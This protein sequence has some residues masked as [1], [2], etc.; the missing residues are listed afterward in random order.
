MNEKISHDNRENFPEDKYDNEGNSPEDTILKDNKEVA[1]EITRLDPEAN[2][3]SKYRE[4][5]K[6]VFSLDKVEHEAVDKYHP[7]V[8]DKGGEHVVY[9]VEGHRDVVVKV[10]TGPLKDTLDK[11]F[12][13]K[14]QK[15]HHKERAV[16]RQD[17]QE[18][19]FDEKDIM[20]KDIA[21]GVKRYE[22]MREWFGKEHVLPQ[23][24]VIAEVPLTKEIIDELYENKSPGFIDKV[25]A[26]ITVQKYTKEVND[27]EHLAI[28]SGYAEQGGVP[29][30]MYS[31]ATQ[32]LIFGKTPEQKI[33]QKELLKVQS[34]L[35]LKKLFSALE[36]NEEI[37]KALKEFVI[38]AIAYSQETGEILDIAG[39]DNIIF[40]KKDH[41]KKEGAWTHLLIDA[42]YPGSPDIIDKSKEVL[43]AISSGQTIGVNE[44]IILLNSFN[45]I[46]T[47]NGLAEQLG[48]E[49]R[50]QIAP[51]G[52]KEEHIDFLKIIK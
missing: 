45:Y 10:A 38:K 4:H 18:T 46:R 22:R 6:K 23:R 37:K 25:K 2:A 12:Y 34:T 50:I 30:K 11:I 26:I 24:R 17:F 13:K 28:V 35:D 21:S 32:H 19:I 14:Y 1:P 41:D 42:I 29:E 20:K 52:M 40:Y 49:E 9:T 5:V 36:K 39:H 51:E 43:S 7:Q 3:L 15:T 27:P 47:I 16:S 8:L 33:D 31:K 44:K 48:V